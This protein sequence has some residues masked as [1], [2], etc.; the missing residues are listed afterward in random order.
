MIR[1]RDKKS[2]NWAS[3]LSKW[4]SLFSGKYFAMIVVYADETGTGGMPK[5]GKD[6]SPGVYGFMATP[7]D[8]EEFRLSWKSG[9]DAHKKAPYFHFC[10]LTRPARKK[11]G[12]RFGDWSDEEVDDFIYDMAVIASSGPIPFG[13]NVSVKMAYGFKPTKAQLNGAYERAFG[14]FFEDFSEQMNQHFPNESGP[15]SFFFENNDT[16]SWIAILDKKIKEAWHRDNRIAHQYTP[17]D[18]KSERGMPCQAA[19]LL[20]FADR[21][22]NETMYDLKMTVPKRVLDIIISRQGH[23]DWHPFSA[24]KKMSNSDWKKLVAE[25]R[26]LRG[27]F[28]MQCFLDGAKDPLPEYYPILDH[29]YFIQLHKLC[30]IHAKKHPELWKFL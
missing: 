22:N 1:V 21:Q 25:L 5:N 28:R 29:P 16:P 23:P 18:S 9:L 19:D 30:K 20:A 11:P 8:W 4:A 3:E 2:Q 17:I 15:V 14:K 10:E 27:Q 26:G 12:S 13:G 7:E 24:L 6:P